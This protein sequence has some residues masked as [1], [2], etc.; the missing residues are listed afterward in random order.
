LEEYLEASLS[1]PCAVRSVSMGGQ[2]GDLQGLEQNPCKMDLEASLSLP[3]AVRSVSMGVNMATSKVWNKIR[4]P[5][6]TFFV[7]SIVGAHLAH[8]LSLPQVAGF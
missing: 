2:Y 7:D 5:G 8:A 6:S 4:A 3:C 1:L